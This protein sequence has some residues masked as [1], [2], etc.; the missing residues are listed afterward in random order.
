M[1]YVLSEPIESLIEDLSCKDFKKCCDVL[2]V[3]SGYGGAIAA[4]RLAGLKRD[5]YVFERGSEHAI[6]EFPESIGEFPSHVQVRG[7]NRDMPMGYADALFDF[8]IGDQVSVLVGNGLGGGSLINANVALEPDDAVFGNLAWPKELRNNKAAL[9]PSFSAVKKLLGVNDAEIQSTRKYDALSRLAE[10]MGAA[11]QPAPITVTQ[12]DGLN[13]V[14]IRQNACVGCANCV[15]GCNV[16]SKNTLSM[17]ALPLAKSRGAKLYTGA[18]VLSIEPQKNA[19]GWKVRFRLTAMSK[20]VMHKEVFTL[21][22]DVV[23]LAAGT[24][25]ST[26]ILL[27][28][29][30]QYQEKHP[31][32]R[33][34]SE[35]LGKRFSTNGDILALG[36][37][38]GAK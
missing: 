33:L 27:R 11:C 38:N 25:G 2:I 29:E 13:A 5:V 10:H 18:T 34:F 30:K 7:P 35:H 37:H 15:T 36:T 31:N 14:G 3:G 32:G 12:Q 6:G 24:L 8:R 22:A 4:M 17:N 26:E 1:S 21:H 16:G 28:S 20:T 19:K 23:I 9:A